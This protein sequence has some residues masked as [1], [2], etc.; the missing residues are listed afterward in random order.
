MAVFCL[1]P[2]FAKKQ[3]NYIAG[4]SV[5]SCVYEAKNSFFGL[6]LS[7]DKKSSYVTIDAIAFCQ[8]RSYKA[9]SRFYLPIWL[10]A[11]FGHNYIAA[12]KFSLFRSS[13]VVKF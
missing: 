11:K 2:A 12:F 9:A 10:I 3:L 13:K 1:Q 8:L 4:F 5:F 6:E 7:Y